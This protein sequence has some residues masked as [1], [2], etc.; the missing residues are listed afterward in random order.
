MGHNLEV[1]VLYFAEMEDL[2][3]D[4]IS[5]SLIHPRLDIIGMTILQHIIGL[6]DLPIYHILGIM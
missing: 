5:V 1:L 2:Q 4:S 6:V 3:L